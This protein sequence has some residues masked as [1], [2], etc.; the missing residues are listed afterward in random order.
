MPAALE[1][2]IVIVGA[3]LAGSTAALRF[4]SCGA[5][6]ALVDPFPAYP[7]DFRCEKLTGA[8]SALAERLGLGNVL[9]S[10]STS[11]DGVMVARGGRLV[12]H[13][14]APERTFRYD[15][16]VNA[17]RAETAATVP[18]FA[19]KVDDI[20][21]NAKSPSVRLSSGE[22]ITARLVV[23]ATGPGEK[24][25][26]SLRMKRRML[27]ENHSIS[28]GFD[29]VNESG[30]KISDRE[31]THFGETAGDGIAYAT[32]FPLGGVTRC[33]FFCYHDPKSDFIRDFRRD[34]L[35]GLLAALPGLFSII[36]PVVRRSRAEIR[37]TDLY[38]VDDPARD[39]VV[40]IG[41]AQHASC[42][43]T[44]TGVTRVLTDVERLCDVYWPR[45]RAADA[46]PADEIAA[47]Y[48]DPEK[49]RVDGLALAKAIRDR[50]Q[51]T[52]TGL[53]VR[54][55]RIGAGVRARM[56]A[57]LAGQRRLSLSPPPG[58]A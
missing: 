50:R 44:G 25:R 28:I 17:V 21:V 24:L 54:A 6:V 5:R 53:G 57:G 26:A 47:Y 48:T 51:A 56:R 36:G 20:T 38:E 55:R 39:G 37:V 22:T 12:E 42:P 34:P 49:Q 35:Q 43:V 41:D 58:T 16:F 8:Q 10:Q 1:T 4:A 9:A 31:L 23:L 13:L 2:E 7:A 11:S 46:I 19:A 33:N 27:G 29:L 18:F 15:Q 40:L 3:G 45:W 14:R 32:L 30:L 52:E